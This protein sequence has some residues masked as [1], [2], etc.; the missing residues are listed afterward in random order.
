MLWFNVCVVIRVGC[1]IISDRSG[2][3]CSAWEC[4]YVGP[5]K[6]ETVDMLV[7]SS[8]KKRECGGA[9]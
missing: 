4:L 5:M 2:S 6:T 8:G 7:P 3:A 1:D 9:V